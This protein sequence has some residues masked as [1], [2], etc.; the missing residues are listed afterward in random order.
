MY[1]LVLVGCGYKLEPSW[2]EVGV[3][4]RVFGWIL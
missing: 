1:G 2:V 4:G 3:I